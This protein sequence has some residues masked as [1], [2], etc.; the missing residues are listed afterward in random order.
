MHFIKTVYMTLV[1][2]IKA[3]YYKGA[4]TMDFCNR[5]IRLKLPNM[6]RKGENL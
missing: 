5:E 3:G 4:T 2:D 6:T 1:K